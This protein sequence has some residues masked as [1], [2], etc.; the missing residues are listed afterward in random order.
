MT[1]RSKP[2]LFSLVIGIDAYD[3]GAPKLSP[4]KRAVAD[5][6]KIKDW[7]LNRLGVPE[8]NIRTL[9][10][11]AATRSAIIQ[12]LKDLSTNVKI[13]RDDPILIYYAGHG[14][15][16]PAPK[17]WNWDTDMI[18]MILPCDY[19]R[20]SESNRAV[21]AIPDRTLGVL[22]SQIAQE[23]GNNI[24]VIM[25][26]CHSGSGTRWDPKGLQARR[27]DYN[28][29]IPGDM[30]EDLMT[31]GVRGFS[32]H[33]R[34]RHAGCRSHVLLAA[35]A[36]DETAY[37]DAHSGV[38]TRGLLNALEAV[39]LSQTTNIGLLQQLTDL[40]RFVSP[41]LWIYVPGVIRNLEF[42]RTLIDESKHRPPLK[43][44]V[45]ANEAQATIG[46]TYSQ[47]CDQ[48]GFNI[49][50]P[51]EEDQEVKYT[52]SPNAD[53]VYGALRHLCHYFYHRDR[54][55]GTRRVREEGQQTPLTL[56]SEVVISMFTLKEDET[57]EENV[58]WRGEE[59]P[60]PTG[61]HRG[62]DL[63]VD[64]DDESDLYGFEIVN[65]SKFDVFVHLFYFN[66]ADFSIAPLYKPVAETADADKAL[67][68]LEAGGSLLIGYGS[69]GTRPM[70]LTLPKDVEYERGSLRMF[71]STQY[72]DLS[73]MEQES[74]SAQSRGIR[75]SHRK[76]VGAFWD[77][78]TIPLVIRK[79]VPG[80]TP[81]IGVI[82]SKRNGKATFI[83]ELFNSPQLKDLN[84]E[85]SPQLSW[86]LVDEYDLT[87]P[88]NPNGSRLQFTL[89]DLPAF[90]DTNVHSQ[91]ETLK[92]LIS[93]LSTRYRQQR[94]FI[95]LIWLYD[96]ST[97]FSEIDRLNLDLVKDI[98]GEEAFRNIVILTT[99]WNNGAMIGTNQG[100]T[101][102]WRTL[103]S[104]ISPFRRY[105]AHEQQIKEQDTDFKA[106]VDGRAQVKRFGVF[107]DQEMAKRAGVS[108]PL[109]VIREAVKWNTPTTFQMQH[110]A[111]ETK[112]LSK[113]TAGKKLHDKLTKE[114]EKERKVL[115]R[116]Q[117]ELEEIERVGSAFL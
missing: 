66:G 106:L 99:Y 30:D 98:T 62:L 114:L 56:A 58:Y 47:Q 10:N 57:S 91:A 45:V 49:L 43:F 65:N 19:G 97:P 101:K 116:L 3:S 60:L 2:D 27:V 9:Q 88:I 22:I 44:K 117:S 61:N 13:K 87:M 107:S 23:K 80:P 82:G 100:V 78:V 15:E 67:V 63:T 112:T 32:V 46:L 17:E 102:H 6:D 24:T 54:V 109:T 12:A 34:F 105:E 48:I 70:Q 85:P 74:I 77:C 4:L 73:F 29:V 28:G 108:D 33:D 55:A 53:D 76:P 37:E 110:E 14:S 41:E 21:P 71:V 16:A 39:D 84:L 51:N 104:A 11:G 26:C 86:P 113:T 68:P 52:V 69:G 38:F 111:S 79:E 75:P 103:A 93:Y 94:S 35:C 20:K 83:R 96:I 50:T 7:L 59:V 72:A 92:E 81:I 89:V 1:S 95:S 31:V 90:E 40:P 42:F 8:S 18:Q 36:P 64:E 25:D 115:L 5:S